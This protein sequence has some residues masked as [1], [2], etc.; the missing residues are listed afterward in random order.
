VDKPRRRNNVNICRGHSGKHIPRENIF[1]VT[2]P[3]S[4]PSANFTVIYPARAKSAVLYAP[5][6]KSAGIIRRLGE[7]THGDVERIFAYDKSRHVNSPVP[8]ASPQSSTYLTADYQTVGS[9]APS[10]RQSGI[11]NCEYSRHNFNYYP[12]GNLVRWKR[13]DR[14][15]TAI[16]MK[17]TYSASRAHYVFGTIPDRIKRSMP[18]LR[19]ALALFSS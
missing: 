5:R 2:T 15:S 17:L 10:R 7:I 13:N 1:A 8:I 11:D 12:P 9:S 19:D 14:D 4:T 6:F 16:P 18:N 3:L